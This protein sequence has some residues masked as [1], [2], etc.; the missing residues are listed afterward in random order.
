MPSAQD[1]Q[2]DSGLLKA[3][4]ILG[5]TGTGKTAAALALAR[6]IPATVINFDSRQV[7]ADFPLITAQPG[8]E[9]R[10]VC[11]H[12]LYGFLPCAES[13][14]A[15]AFA[16]LAEAE[17]ERAVSLGRL[18]VL[19]GGTG[20]YLRALVRGLADI[21]DVP[22]EIRERIARRIAEEGSA[23]LHAELAR[24]D[25]EYAASVHPNNR[26]RVG[27]ALEVFLATGKPFS[28]WHAEQAADDG[29][30]Y[31]KAGGAHGVAAPDPQAGAPHRDHA[32][33]GRIGRG[34]ARPRG[35]P[36]HLGPGLD[37]HRVR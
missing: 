10:E 33:H 14:G 13:I 21:P 28:R 5:P 27:R 22:G 36:G 18:P 32:G 34:P 6:R 26:Q 23:A 15:A 8:Q 1:I 16:S 31:L 20:L 30:R 35:L 25:P 11:P 17:I 9:E 24:V 2:N 29:G 19:V 37:R 12:V 7:Y 3:V 4:C